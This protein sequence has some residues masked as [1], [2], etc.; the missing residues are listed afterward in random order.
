M[1][2]QP[3]SSLGSARRLDLP[4]VS[5]RLGEKIEEGT[6]HELEKT[7]VFF[8][9]RV[10]MDEDSEGITV[11]VLANLTEREL[12]DIVRHFLRGHHEIPSSVVAENRGAPSA[13]C[14][15]PY[16]DRIEV[17][18][19]VYLQGPDWVRAQ[20]YTR[21]LVH[22]ALG[23][24]FDAPRMQVSALIPRDVLLRSGYYKKF[25]N[26]VNAVSRIRG[27]YWDGVAVAQLRPRQTDAMSSFYV[28]SDLVLN[29]VTCYHI[30][31]AASDL[32]KRHNTG[33]FIIEGPVFRH[34]S[35]NHTATR[36]GEFTM[37]EVVRLG[38]GEEV[39]GTFRSMVEVFSE[40]FT[41]LGLPYR[42]V[43]ASDAFF[44]DNPSLARAAQMFNSSKYEVRV[45]MT[46]GELSVA[47]VNLHGKVFADSFGFREEG[48]IDETCCAGIGI[49]RL[50]YALKSF[51]LLPD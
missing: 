35:H 18:T 33:T 12:W 47:S 46:D 14:S 25:P 38:T 34:E 6:L 23:S 45:P 8:Y 48:R 4:T 40:F 36:L 51:G 43:S 7:L 19:G 28:P 26:L 1:S 42:I 39:Q 15:L 21:E 10:S 5:I 24:R 9:G 31:A 50:A 2:T 41:G 49:D 20:E 16:D 44:G 29:P 37:V 32:I 11:T 13:H 17:A 22:Q 3:Q 27:E 30:Y